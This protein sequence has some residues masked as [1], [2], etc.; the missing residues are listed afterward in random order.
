[1]GLVI[2]RSDKER[3][4]ATMAAVDTMPPVDA[5]AMKAKHIE[6]EAAV[7]VHRIRI[8]LTSRNVKNLEKVCADLIRGAKEKRLKV[9]GPVRLPT[10][11]LR[12]TTR[13]SP[14]G[15]GTS[16]LF[17]MLV[18]CMV[19]CVVAVAGR[20]DPCTRTIQAQIRGTALR[21]ASTS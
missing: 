15:E 12:I 17:R 4:V 8:T 7:K 6:E 10:K 11:V 3:R 2:D 14:C 20:I 1:M 5:S 19:L 9:K 18:R 16:P 21:C 13:K